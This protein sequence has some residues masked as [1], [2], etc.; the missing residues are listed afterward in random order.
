MVVAAVLALG[1][2]G[3]AELAAPDDQRLFEQAALL[4]VGEQP[5]DRQVGLLA[6]R[7]GAGGVVG[8]SVPRLAGHEELD[9]PD[10]AL[11]QPPGHQAARSVGPRDRV[12]EAVERLR[13]GDSCD[14]SSASVA[15]SCMRAA[16]SKLAMRAS[17][18]SSSGWR[19]RCSALSCESSSSRPRS[20]SA[21]RGVRGLRF[22]TGIPS[23]RNGVPW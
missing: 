13:R 15:E 9:E 5:G 1:A 20:T 18:S 22:K 4:Q 16:S 7:A 23:A 14:R 6:A 10:A 11:D 3:S 2:G 12:V 19:E 8:V 17:S 21:G